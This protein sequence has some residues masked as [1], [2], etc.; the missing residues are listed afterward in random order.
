[1]AIYAF[2]DTG[3]DRE[4]KVGRGDAVTCFHDAQGYSPRGI[5]CIALWE[6]GK[7]N[8]SGI[9]ETIHR[10]L[11]DSHGQFTSPDASKPY[12]GEEWFRLHATEAAETI[13]EILRARPSP[14]LK[15][16]GQ[17]KDKLL[18]KPTYKGRLVLWIMEEFHT[19]R[20]K[21]Y[22]CSEWRSPREIRKRYSRNGFRAVGAYTYGANVSLCRNEEVDKLRLQCL[23]KF[24]APAGREHLGWL[25]AGPKKEEVE[26][27]VLRSSKGSLLPVTDFLSES[28]RPCGVRIDYNKGLIPEAEIRSCFKAVWW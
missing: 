20:L 10:Q 28:A 16:R 24:G 6:V 2:R 7:E 1:M 21:V 9:E 12:S 15:P 4:T 17:R 3:Y 14:A 19:G 23:E 25:V 8:E 13:S 18:S 22:Q 5:E 11:G 26:H 27:F